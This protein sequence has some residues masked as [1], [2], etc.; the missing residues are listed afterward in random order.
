MS[1]SGIYWAIW[2]LFCYFVGVLLG[3][4]LR[5]QEQERK[6]KENA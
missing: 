2:G 5:K 6:E 3:Y 1:I 4:Y